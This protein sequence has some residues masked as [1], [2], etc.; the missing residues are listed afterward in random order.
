MLVQ[1]LR[2]TLHISRCKTINVRCEKEAAS[3]LTPSSPSLLPSLQ[4]AECESRGGE[5]QA[6]V[7]AN[8]SMVGKPA[9][10][11]G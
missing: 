3:L 8:S 1:T 6:E 5:K 7:K 4:D 9:D 11:D 10:R 2:L